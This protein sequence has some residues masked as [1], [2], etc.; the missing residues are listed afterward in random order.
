MKI[1]KKL[2][3]IILALVICAA[4]VATTWAANKINV[5]YLA[6]LDASAI[7]VEELAEKSENVTLTIKADK[8]VAMDALQ[9]QV[10]VPNGWKITEITNEK[11]PGFGKGNSNLEETADEQHYGLV[12]WFN[13][14]NQPENVTT[15]L[16]ATVTIQVPA[17]T[18]AGEY[19]I[20]CEIIEISRDYGMPWEDGQTISA[21]LTIGTHTDGDD[22]DH[23]C[24]YCQG[25][26]E[27]ATCAFVPGEPA[28][29]E[30]NS[31][32]T[33]V[34]TCACG[35]TATANGVITTT[36]T[37][38]DC[39]TKKVTT[40]IA[41]FSETW[42]GKTVTKEV[43]GEVNPDVHASANLT[44]VDE[45]AP[46]CGDD[47]VAAYWT[48]VCG[49]LFA[50]EQATQ[51]IE[52]L[53]AWKTGGGRIPATE[54]HVF[55]PGEPVWSDDN[56]TVTVTGTCVCGDTATASVSSS[57]EVTPGTCQTAELTTYTA[58]FDAEWITEKT[59]TKTVEG[60]LDG[61]KHIGEQST[62][63]IN[64]GEDHTVTITCQCGGV[65]SETPEEHS[66][67]DGSCVCGAVDETPD[68]GGT[69]KGD[70][71][72]DGEVNSIDLTMLTSHVYGI[73]VLTDP[74]ALAN[75]DVNDDGDYNSNDIT[76]H[77]QYVYGI[78]TDWD[79]E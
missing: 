28:W 64:N 59:V 50:D 68:V 54:Q 70:V 4:L 7:C 62:A 48:C 49:K 12:A 11:L 38:G 5:T 53:D 52:D 56:K 37:I 2:S 41:A 39:Q 31:S 20:D 66:Y 33:V 55:V 22:A 3:S 67:V 77:A 25:V 8:E 1:A 74:V 42:F 29:A 30:D 21:T 19:K 9:M 60:E 15:D 73:E 51:L 79:Q 76:K 10:K 27:G 6:T 18:P 75:A 72:L 44:K 43:E 45:V 47:G 23:L 65:I 69:L 61:D 78:I 13:E 17:N 71:N 16:L 58:V 26:V 32:C 63:Y 34:G 24:D 14:S 57:S 46:T 40:Y 35:K 36:E